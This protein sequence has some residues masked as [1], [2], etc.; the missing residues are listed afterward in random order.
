M[1]RMEGKQLQMESQWDNQNQHNLF[2]VSVLAWCWGALE[3]AQWLKA[4]VMESEKS[5]FKPQEQQLMIGRLWVDLYHS[6][7]P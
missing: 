3:V 1:I 6:S 4:R 7:E 2:L 5:E